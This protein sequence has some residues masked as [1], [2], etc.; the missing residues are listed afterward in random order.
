MVIERYRVL[1]I[2][3]RRVGVIADGRMGKL[4]FGRRCYWFDDEVREPL[5]KCERMDTRRCL[6][7]S[8]RCSVSS[9]RSGQWAIQHEQRAQ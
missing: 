5:G 6:S 8:T 1:S 7:N 9:V 2:S 3:R 4:T